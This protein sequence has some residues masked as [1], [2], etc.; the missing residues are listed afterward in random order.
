M[1]FEIKENGEIVTCK[2]TNK[3]IERTQLPKTG[4]TNELIFCGIGA[5]L[6]GLLLILIKSKKKIEK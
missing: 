4:E 2:M 6:S 1:K 5:I 3:K